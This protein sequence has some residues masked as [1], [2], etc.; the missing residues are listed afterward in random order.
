MIAPVIVTRFLSKKP[1]LPRAA[2]CSH[3]LFKRGTS[4]MC[5]SDL[6]FLPPGSGRRVAAAAA[7]VDSK[8]PMVASRMKKSTKIK[9]EV[10]DPL[11]SRVKTKKKGIKKKPE[12]MF[13]R[14]RRKSRRPKVVTVMTTKCW[15][16]CDRSRLSTQMTQLEEKHNYF[17][18]GP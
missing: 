17:S 15:R 11:T 8:T 16:R 1:F 18:P 14:A 7:V 3:V 10:H 13:K 4:E 6:G 12:K 2:R 5:R 9:T